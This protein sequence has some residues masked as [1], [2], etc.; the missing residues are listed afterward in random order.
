VS[1]VRWAGRG[2][3]VLLTVAAAG[4]LVLVLRR[5]SEADELRSR[6]ADEL[7]AAPK[8]P[9]GDLRVV[10]WDE[11]VI[12]A[13][14][15]TG[16]GDVRLHNG[17]ALVASTRW[18]NAWEGHEPA[19]LPGQVQL[20]YEGDAQFGDLD[21]D[22]VAEAAVRFWCENGSGMAGG[23]LAVTIAVFESTPGSSRVVGIV[24]AM[25]PADAP[26]HHAPLIGV[27]SMDAGGLVVDESWYG[28]NDSTAGPTGSATSTWSYDGSTLRLE[29][30]VVTAEPEP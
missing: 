9:A 23:Q 4:A 28:P 10:D 22:G 5:T 25:Q 1:P 6:H 19:Q 11:A 26:T 7:V 3:L 8:Y 18:P 24:G 16:V 15:C 21:G 27:A 29:A 30:T 20:Y 2:V 12:P 14:V 17:S 13:A